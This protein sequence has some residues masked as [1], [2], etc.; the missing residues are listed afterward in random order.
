MTHISITY[1]YVLSGFLGLTATIPMVDI[2]GIMIK[3]PTIT[4]R[5]KNYNYKKIN[6]IKRLKFLYFITHTRIDYKKI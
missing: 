5:K 2:I 3:P 1:Q 4:I 6:N